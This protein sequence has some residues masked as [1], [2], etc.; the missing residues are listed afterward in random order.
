MDRLR[1]M[2]VFVRAVEAGSFRKAS[3]SLGM[4]AQ[5][6]GAH[7]R[8]LEERLGIRLFH[9]TTRCSAPTDGGLLFYERCKAILADVHDAEAL[10]MEADGS[11]RGAIRVTAP[12]TYGNALLMP[13]L[14]VFLALHPELTLDLNLS[15][16]PAD[17]IAD[18]FDL[19]I[20]I[21]PLADSTAI[22]RR[23]PDYRLML[24]AA[25]AY[26]AA[27]GRPETLEELAAHSCLV[28]QWWTGATWSE[29]P[30]TREGQ[31]TAVRVKPRLVSNQATVLVGAAKAGLGIAMLPERL[32][33]DEIASGAL[34][35]L[36]PEWRCP[37]REVHL[38]FVERPTA[39]VRALVDHVVA[40]SE[41]A[42]GANAGFAH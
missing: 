23:L 41:R 34:V 14:A 9:R 8:S 11:L 13:A 31:T 17:L 40:T 1:S 38:L 18:R 16:R 2:T 26:L 25:P 15:D 21:G 30:L 24:G 36:L 6:V 28:F 19:A 20:R 5:M 32:A 7:V 22:T 37:T 12:V 42:A 35:P 29:W 4:T 39:R 33:R 27:H 10:A 3:G